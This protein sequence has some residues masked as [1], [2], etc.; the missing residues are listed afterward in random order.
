[1]QADLIVEQAMAAGAAQKP[2]ELIGLVD[3]VQEQRPS[4]VLEIGTMSGGTLRAWCAC[5]ADD[6]QITSIDLPDGRW[7][8]G[9]DVS[10]V[11]RLNSYTRDAQNLTLIRG[12][13]HDP[14]IRADVDHLE[15]DFLFIDGD[16]TYEGVKRD[17]EDYS[18]LVKAGG[19]IAFHDVLPHPNVP[20]CDVDQL[21]AELRERHEVEEFL[22]PEETHHEWGQWGGIGVVKWTG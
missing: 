14:V 1:M 2:S 4:T 12:D 6:A 17:F 7:G 22:S 3:L 20:E 13:S 9:Y 8:G 5:A 18:P 15:I 10:E 19:L 16:H 21:W 11:A